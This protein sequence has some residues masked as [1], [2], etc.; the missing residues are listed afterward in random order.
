MPLLSRLAILLLLSVLPVRAFAEV[1]HTPTDIA[2]AIGKLRDN[3]D[4]RELL[5]KIAFYYMNI[6]SDSLISVYADR[7][8]DLGKRTGDR[9][10]CELYGHIAKA[11]VYLEK[12]D[13][14]YFAHIERARSIAE[15]TENLDAMVSVY[16]SLAI[17]YFYTYSDYYTAA[18]YYYMALDCAKSIGDQ[19]RISI[20]L[21]NLSG[22]YIMLNDL[23]G[24]SVAEQAYEISHKLGDPIPM[25]YSAYSLVSYYLLDNRPELAQQML[26]ETERLHAR[27]ELSGENAYLGLHARIAEA[28]GNKTEA[29]RM[30]RTVMESFRDKSIPFR[31]ISS[32][33]LNYAQFLR[34]VKM[35]QDAI[36]VLE[37]GIERSESDSRLWVPQFY[38]ELV[39]ACR[40]QGALEKALDY[41]IKYQDSQDSLFTISRERTFQENR[42]RYD[43]E[44]KERKIDEQKLELASSRHRMVVLV[45]ITIAIVLLFAVFVYNYR[46][47]RH[48]YRAIVLQNR[49]YAQ[50]EKLLL[51]QQKPRTLLTEEKTDDIISR[52]T[53]LMTEQKLYTDPDITVASV[54]ERLETNRTYLSRSINDSTGKSFTQ[55][56]NDYRVREAIALLSDSEQNL[57]LKQIAS[58][59]GFS[60]LS[61]FYSS[62]QTFTG[63]TPA[64]YREQLTKV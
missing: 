30:Y 31:E 7:L 1:L 44:S 11:S 12:N 19:R 14:S 5:K 64:R 45:I 61:T 23:N 9:D 15:S 2:E 21:S 13:M 48:L 37:E 60:S 36:K 8:L 41:S 56:V 6:S 57:P 29:F 33:Y 10:F 16:N 43:I 20:I 25:Y 39:Y 38:R 17:H 28:M 18:S 40:E 49:D 24:L 55:V 50:R 51:Q 22:T 63:M 4:D 42:I 59:A 62:F 32:T 35:P 46:R 34:K 27:L 26:Q 58:M 54:G 52:F 3:P 53:R 47:Q